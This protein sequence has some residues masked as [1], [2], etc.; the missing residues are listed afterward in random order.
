[1]NTDDIVK[2]FRNLKAPYPRSAS[3]LI[4]DLCHELGRVLQE[5]PQDQ[6]SIDRLTDLIGQCFRPMDASWPPE[7][8]PWDTAYFAFGRW[9]RRELPHFTNAVVAI[10]GWDEAQISKC[11]SEY[12]RLVRYT[13]DD[14]ARLA[15]ALDTQNIGEPD[16]ARESPS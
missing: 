1:M 5:S 3:G 8:C 12:V 2:L 13:R 6:P 14:W 7:S 15:E 4:D 10:T 16:D 11:R 9:L